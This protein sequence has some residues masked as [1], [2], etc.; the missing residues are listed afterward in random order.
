MLLL[1]LLIGAGS[2]ALG[3]LALR[4]TYIHWVERFLGTRNR[5]FSGRGGY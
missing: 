1:W 3:L 2:F 5:S 4:I